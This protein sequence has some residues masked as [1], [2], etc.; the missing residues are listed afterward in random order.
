D[1][2]RL[3]PRRVLRIEVIPDG[4][5]G[6]LVPEMDDQPFAGKHLQGWGRIE[7]AAR[8]LAVRRSAADHLIVKKEKVL[9]RSGHRIECGAALTRRQA[10]FEDAFSARQHYR[11]TELRSN[12]GIS[13]SLRILRPSNRDRAYQ[14]HQDSE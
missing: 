5:A 7:I 2:N 9:D 8:G 14:T 13:S 3:P 12:C 6:E 4:Q 10:D 11:L 1:R